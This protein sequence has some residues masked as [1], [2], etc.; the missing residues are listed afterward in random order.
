M[1]TQSACKLRDDD[2]M[3]NTDDVNVHVAPRQHAW[4]IEL[5]LF[6]HPL[7][8]MF[9]IIKWRHLD[10]FRRPSPGTFPKPLSNLLRN[11]GG[12]VVTQFRWRPVTK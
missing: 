2:M 4:D 7:F 10:A 12:R 6:S 11:G 8:K 3:C 5:R 9:K 1:A